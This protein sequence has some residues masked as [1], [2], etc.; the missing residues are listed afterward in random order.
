MLLPC[1]EQVWT[2]NGS[3]PALVS[4]E[5]YQVGWWKVTC[6]IIFISN[7]YFIQSLWMLNTL[8][9]DVVLANVIVSLSCTFLITAFK[10]SS[11]DHLWNVTKHIIWW[12]SIK[13]N[14]NVIVNGEDLGKCHR[15]EFIDKTLY[16][17]FVI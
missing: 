3:N 6:Q 11:G 4:P 8:C 16:T 9:I 17:I 1:D 14:V 10:V 13:C 12:W 5:G 15:N 7:L 2:R